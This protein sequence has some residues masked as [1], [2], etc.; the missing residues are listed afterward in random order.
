M[1]K[2]NHLYALI[3]LC[4]LC[5]YLGFSVTRNATDVDTKTPDVPY[6]KSSGVQCNE[7]TAPTFPVSLIKDDVPHQAPTQPPTEALTEHPTQPPT[8]PR[9]F[10]PVFP[11]EGTISRGFSQTPVFNPA[12]GDWRSHPGIDIDAPLTEAVVAIEDGTVTAVYEDPIWGNVIEIDH[13]EYVS[14]Y[15]NLSTLAMVKIGDYISRG[16]T[17]SGVGE[18]CGVEKGVPH[19]HL[20]ITHYSEII[21]PSELFG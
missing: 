16:E 17:I 7:T 20:E 4:A 19:L 5:A 9:G 6:E 12:T 18:S 13:G 8:P 1:L 14:S 21:D 15:K 11:S 3:S 10:S 2:K